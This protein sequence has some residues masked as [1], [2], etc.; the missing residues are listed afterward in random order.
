[1]SAENNHRRDFLKKSSLLLLS[2]TSANFLSGCSLMPVF[3]GDDHDPIID[4]HTHIF[5]SRDQQQLA[6]L[7]YVFWAQFKGKIEFPEFLDKFI[8]G[9]GRSVANFFERALE[10]V[11]PT[12]TEES[13]L[14]E[15]YLKSI[16]GYRHDLTL[17]GSIS[18]SV[19]NEQTPTKSKIQLNKEGSYDAEDFSSAFN[20]AK[21]NIIEQAEKTNVATLDKDSD[22]ARLITD[23]N[24]IR[25]YIAFRK[26]RNAKA[27]NS[28]LDIKSMKDSALVAKQ[29]YADWDFLISDEE[30]NNVFKIEK[31]NNLESF[32]A[33]QASFRDVS[34]FIDLFLKIKA[35][36]EFLMTAMRSHVGNAR[37]LVKEFED[38]Q[39]FSNAKKGVDYFITANVDMD[40]WINASPTQSLVKN[41]NHSYAQQNAL[42]E[43]TA[44]VMKGRIL[45]MIAFDPWREYDYR[46]QGVAIADGPLEL[47][48]KSILSHGFVGIKLYPPMGFWPYKNANETNWPPHAPNDP[49]FGQ[50]LDNI[51]YELFEFC[52]THDVP[53]MAHANESMAS[54]PGYEARASA[55]A[56]E[57]LLGY[58]DL[59]GKQPF[60]NLR[61]NLGHAGGLRE[62]TQ[63]D[64]KWV[65]A[66][67]ELS[68]KYPNVYMDF[69][70]FDEIDNSELRKKFVKAIAK[71]DKVAQKK[72]MYGSDWS[73]LANYYLKHKY[74]AYMLQSGNAISKQVASDFV[75][76]NSIRFLGFDDKQNANALRLIAFY[77]RHGMSPPDI[78]SY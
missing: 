8:T 38:T 74:L 11:T 30:F 20:E 18:K 35:W 10:G 43:K 63:N 75:G 2:A 48:K 45:P 52:I 24:Q 59:S 72:I 28:M 73:M 76:N 14:L 77:H 25:E 29:E 56:W 17:A 64:S 22:E 78:V 23:L 61:L 7:V 39:W 9:I 54:Q 49:Q 53:V 66:I 37:A 21:D 4:A 12:Y 33:I 3:Y 31:V 15:N 13:E 46:K 62:I 58:T 47:L 42:V 36:I 50:A 55:Q 68:I 16:P 44:L 40:F 65:Q 32:T 6:V 67:V 57:K 19:I 26:K 51:L 69:S 41:N 34:K 5:N 71:L 27:E 1:M 70:N 60:K